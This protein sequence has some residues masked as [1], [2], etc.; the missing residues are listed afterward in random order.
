MTRPQAIGKARMS[1]DTPSSLCRVE[2]IGDATLY[3][4]DC[5]EL[6]P[7]LHADA[8]ITD[9]PY[10]IAYTHSGL[11]KGK[12]RTR[13]SGIIAGDDLPF[14]PML[15]LSF[16]EC[17]LF[18]ANHFAHLLPPNGRWLV[19]DKKDGMAS[20]S[21]SDCEFVW[22]SNPGAARLK[23]YL[24]NGIAMAGEKDEPQRWHPNQKPIEIMAWAIGFTKGDCVADPYMGSGTTGVAA[25]RLGRKFVGIEIEPRWFDI[26]CRRIEEEARQPRLFIDPPRRQI[27]Q[28]KL[29]L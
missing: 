26:A 9:P 8:I 19:W 23:R 24:W 7:E 13:H 28:G 17:L 4:G 18:G 14:N 1:E 12:H 3:L 20:N 21:F 16:P 6:L 11:G 10:G 27:E 15:A 2:H 5:R 22:C 29:A 25:L